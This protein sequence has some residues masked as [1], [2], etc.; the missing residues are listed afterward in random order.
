MHG[1]KD[2]ECPFA[3]LHDS[4]TPQSRSAVFFLKMA[5]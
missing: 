1:K 2:D 4:V 3:V 5:C